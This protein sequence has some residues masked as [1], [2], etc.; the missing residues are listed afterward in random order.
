MLKI[1][2]AAAAAVVG[3][4]PFSLFVCLALVC[5]V[6]G[7]PFQNCNGRM[8]TCRR[9]KWIRVRELKQKKTSAD[10]AGESSGAETPRE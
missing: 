6:Q 8:V 2:V 7:G 10:A 1:H 4:F 3:L 5:S 9:R